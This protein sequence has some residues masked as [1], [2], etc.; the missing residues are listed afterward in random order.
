[1]KSHAEE[2]ES[3]R[4]LSEK[5][6][7]WDHSGKPTDSDESESK[8]GSH[9]NLEM[10]FH[11]LKHKAS[12]H[13]HKRE[14]MCSQRF[15]YRLSNFLASKLLDLRLCSGWDGYV[16]YYMG[17]LLYFGQNSTSEI[18]QWLVNS[19]FPQKKLP[20]RQPGCFQIWDIG[21]N[22]WSQLSC[23]LRKPEDGCQMFLT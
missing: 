8:P 10:R 4:P 17:M 1:M 19:L 15:R 16:M 14:Q 20:M 18:A 3:I 2:V 6:T 23:K 12:K 13:P 9:K 11:H 7:S 5:V 21:R 22:R